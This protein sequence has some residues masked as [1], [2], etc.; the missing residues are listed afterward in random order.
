MKEVNKALIPSL[1]AKGSNKY[2]RIFTDVEAET[3]PPSW[4]NELPLANGEPL[5]LDVFPLIEDFEIVLEQIRGTSW[6]TTLHFL[7]RSEGYIASFPWWDHVELV[8]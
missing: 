1:K 7:A 5:P 2:M 3:L 8:E 4:N 6:D